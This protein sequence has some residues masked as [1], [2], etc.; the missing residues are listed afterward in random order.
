MKYDDEK[1]ALLWYGLWWV[2]TSFTWI[3]YWLFWR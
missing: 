2:V 1:E 3:S